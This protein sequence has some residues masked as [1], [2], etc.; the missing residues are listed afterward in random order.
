ME[1]NYDAYI[2][3]IYDKH[4]W[5]C[6]DPT[7]ILFGGAGSGKSN[8]AIYMIV[9]KYLLSYNGFKKPEKTL[10]VRKVANTLNFTLWAPVIALIKEMG[11]WAQMKVNATLRSIENMSNGNSIIMAG[12]DD[13]DKLKSIH[14]VTKIFIEEADGATDT[15]ILQLKMR[16][17]GEYE[18]FYQM[19]M[20]FNPVS[21]THSLVKHAEPQYLPEID[22]PKNFVGVEYLNENKTAWRLTFETE[23]G[24]LSHTTVLNTNYK[25]NKKLD[26]GYKTTLKLMASIDEVYAQVYEHGRWGIA[27]LGNMYAHQY[28]ISRH[29]KKV[30]YVQ[31]M[32]IHYTTDF[33]V[34]PHMTGLCI[35]FWSEN[36]RYKVQVMKGLALKYPN[37]EAFYLGAEFIGLFEDVISSGVF[38]YGD[39]SG[40]NRTGIGG[41]VKTLFQDVLKGFGVYAYAI[42]KRVPS[43]NP[44]YLKIAPNS[45]GRKTFLNAILSGLLPIDLIIDP[46]CTELIH[47]LE[48]CTQDANGKLAKPKNKLGF[49]E[50]GHALQALEY[51]LCHH[52]TLGKL[53]LL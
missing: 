23:D 31:N 52:E 51:F 28:R 29:V 17:R 37:N 16:M 30:E 34:S 4:I 41:D 49:E 1:I 13:V 44:R 35:Q 25:H 33:N 53:A 5:N 18:G 7:I 19:I 22:R 14:G 42:E 20:C 43:S 50:R 26:E 6:T 27:A 46:S 10:F 36:N 2:N 11:V 48:Q 8:F 32:P 9:E 38:L 47:D 24:E 3:P 21:K 45:M 39:A 15:D 40:N 12:L